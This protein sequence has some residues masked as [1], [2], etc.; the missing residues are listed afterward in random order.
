MTDIDI[1]RVAVSFTQQEIDDLLELLLEEAERYDD[2]GREGTFD[3][4]RLRPIYDRLKAAEREA[5]E[6]SRRPSR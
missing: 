2:D 4:S 6:R 3:R 1:I 5:A